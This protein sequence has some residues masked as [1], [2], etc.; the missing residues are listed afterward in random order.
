[1]KREKEFGFG[2]DYVKSPSGFRPVDLPIDHPS[3]LLSIGPL[4]L[5]EGVAETTTGFTHLL[6]RLAFTRSA[7]QRVGMHV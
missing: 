2:V 1:M 6:F 3:I 4:C 7:S 5:S